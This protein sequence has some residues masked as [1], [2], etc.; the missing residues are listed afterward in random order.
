[1]AW[2]NLFTGK[3]P[4]RRHRGVTSISVR[5]GSKKGRSHGGHGEKIL[6][7]ALGTPNF[8]LAWCYLIQWKGSRAQASWRYLYFRPL[9]RDTLGNAGL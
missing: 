3:I 7:N 8:G 1:L 6:V 9:R 2:F 4:V 5:N